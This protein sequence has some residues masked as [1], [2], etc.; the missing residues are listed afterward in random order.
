[1]TAR[2]EAKLSSSIFELGAPAFSG[3]APSLALVLARLPR[4]LARARSRSIRSRAPGGVGQNGGALGR[5]RS[6]D[7]QSTGLSVHGG[8]LPEADGHDSPREDLKVHPQRASLDV[9][10]IE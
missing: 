6:P 5:A 8:V 2:V 3:K 9:Q 7:R 1:M 10:A 4:P